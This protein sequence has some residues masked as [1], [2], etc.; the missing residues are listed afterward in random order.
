MSE[1]LQA[2]LAQVY[3]DFVQPDTER[4]LREV[5]A[6]REET[7]DFRRDVDSHFDANYKRLRDLESELQSLVAAVKRLE[8]QIA[9][10]QRN[11]EE[12][13]AARA[14]A[15]HELDQIKNQVAELQ[16]KIAELEAQL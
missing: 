3:R 8:T 12:Q 5:A 4:V 14:E 2:T 1:E 6:G 16:E 7:A 13:A 11:G 15:R 10:L 9:A